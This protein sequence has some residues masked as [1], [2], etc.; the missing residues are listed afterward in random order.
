MDPIGI[1]SVQSILMNATQ[2]RLSHFHTAGMDTTV[3]TSL[4]PS[5]ADAMDSAYTTHNTSMRYKG[6]EYTAG[7]KLVY[8]IVNIGCTITELPDRENIWYDVLQKPMKNNVLRFYLDFKKLLAHNVT[9]RD[10]AE[11]CFGN[12]YDWE[13]SPDFMGMIDVDIG[14]SIAH[15]TPCLSVINTLV[16]GTPNIISS[17]KIGDYV[18]TQGTDVLIACRL[19]NIDKSSITSNNVKEVQ[20]LYG[21]EAA[22]SVLEDL[23]ESQ[24]VVSDFMTRTGIVLPFSKTV[25]VYRKGFVTSMGFERP[26]LD[27][28]AAITGKIDY[29]R[30]TSLY[31]DMIKGIDP[32]A[33]YDIS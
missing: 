31:E 32:S 26:R 13:V 21:I 27:I 14:S 10:I 1:R 6:G 4:R 16:C 30:Y 5:A 11:K 20:K 9:L 7:K 28:K 22:A 12:D 3:E 18:I 15:I 33:V 24:N 8:F 23:L 29:S 19:D 2:K 25:E 17:K